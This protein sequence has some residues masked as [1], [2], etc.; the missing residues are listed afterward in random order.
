MREQVKVAVEVDLSKGQIEI[1]IYG[2]KE[3]IE[4]FLEE[5]EDAQERGEIIIEKIEIKS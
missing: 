4:E 1:K 3:L 2:S 5:L